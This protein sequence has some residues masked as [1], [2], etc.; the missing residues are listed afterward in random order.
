MVRSIDQLMTRPESPPP[1][2]SLSLS[3]ALMQ[4]MMSDFCPAAEPGTTSQTLSAGDRPALLAIRRMV[5]DGSLDGVIQS[6]AAAAAAARL[7]RAE[8]RLER[9]IQLSQAVLQ[10]KAS[11][12]DDPAFGAE[13]AELVA[14]LAEVRSVRA[15]HDRVRR[16]IPWQ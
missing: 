7:G 6:L 14:L 2:P 10:G 3:L 13:R 4:V 15:K 8:D 16:D 1:P 12:A 5:Q 9:R 11:L